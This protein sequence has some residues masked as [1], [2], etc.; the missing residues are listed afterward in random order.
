MVSS[1]VD[2]T[3]QSALSAYQRLS[4]DEKLAFLW[5]VYTKM[6]TSI[7]P[8]APGAAGDEIAKGLFNQVKELSHEEQLQVQRQIIEK[9]DSLIGREYG[10]LSENTKLLFWYYLAQGMEEGVI[11]PM[12][13]NYEPSGSIQKLLSDIEACD[14]EQQITFLREAVIDAGQEPKSGAE[15]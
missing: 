3:V 8:A 11:I 6:G 7:T 13:E 12:P 9:Q 1:N 2:A 10:S 5:Y 4:T 14:F 15:I